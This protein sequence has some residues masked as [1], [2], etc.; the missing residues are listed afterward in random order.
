[1]GKTDLL[2]IVRSPATVFSFK[3]ILITSGQ[4]NS[5]LLKRRLHYYVKKGGLLALRRGLYAKD[6]H[7]NTLE[8]A[9]K[10]YKPSYVSFET[11][12][13]EAGVIFQYY[14]TIFVATYKTTELV[15]DHQTY[16]FRKIRDEILTNTAGIEN[17]GTYFI[18]TKERAF[19]DTLYLNK[20]Y[21]FDNLA[22]L[23][24]QK[25]QKLL[26]LYNNKRMAKMV[27]LYF[28]HF[29]EQER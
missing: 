3:E 17:R 18:A 14:K 8:L 9:T 2:S 4:T 22:P 7:Y 24:L 16:N 13:R 10:I 25:I 27:D 15:C 5:D 11:V 23:D 6:Q 20:E 1:M 21:H 19:L 26:P 28:K 29:A 12:L